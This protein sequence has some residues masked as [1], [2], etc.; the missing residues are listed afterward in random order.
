LS[1]NEARYVTEPLRIFA[2]SPQFTEAASALEARE[3]RALLIVKEA[4]DNAV[5]TFVNSDLAP[6]D[7]SDKA[8]WIL[9]DSLAMR[10]AQYL[11]SV[12][13]PDFITPLLTGYD[14]IGAIDVIARHYTRDL[15][16][17]GNVAESP[18]ICVRSSLAHGLSRSCFLCWNRR[19]IVHS[20]NRKASLR[21]LCCLHRP[22]VDY[23][24][25]VEDADDLEMRRRQLPEDVGAWVAP[26]DS[27]CK[28]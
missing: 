16:D 3:T 28:N 14:D 20:E 7:C 1:E 8:I 21:I 18:K 26:P 15:P 2:G 9:L 23:D 24:P 27:L 25:E 12:L 22:T 4:V 17:G 19:C 11:N 6:S 10:N 5:A 13:S